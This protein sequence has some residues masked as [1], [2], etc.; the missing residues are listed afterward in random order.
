[1][2][3][4]AL[5]LFVGIPVGLFFGTAT[6]ALAVADVVEEDR[7]SEPQPVPNQDPADYTDWARP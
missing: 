1:M 5:G 3:E 4:F 6:G 7:K 2:I